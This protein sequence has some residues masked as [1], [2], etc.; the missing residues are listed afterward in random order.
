MDVFAEIESRVSAALDALKSEGALPSDVP[1]TGFEV[2][3]PRD[4]T[5]G[6][7][8]CNAAMVLAKPARMKPRDIADKLQ[9]KLAAD[10]DVESV[11]VAGPGFLNIT[12]KP[13]FWHGLVRAVHA[14]GGSY[15]RTG[16]GQG[17]SVN[18]EY[19]S[20]NP[21]RPMHV[22]HC[23]GAVFGDALANLLAFAGF[24]VTRE[25][26]INDA[27]GQVDVLARTARVQPGVTNL[28]IT[29]AVQADGFYYDA[30]PGTL[31]RSGVK[32]IGAYAA[33]YA[34]IVYVLVLRF[35]AVGALEKNETR[36]LEE[37]L[38]GEPG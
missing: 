10:N 38:T 7:L 31:E 9:A 6:D 12:M 26:Y 2:E 36:I 24:E 30:H 1:S 5:H 16:I 35:Y 33:L 25:Y 4:P 23:R 8:A 13:A 18:V 15:G 32:C 28:A 34:G 17:Q 11:S 3:A 27:G 14:E 37:C 22:G 20:A 21:T 29:H 19:V